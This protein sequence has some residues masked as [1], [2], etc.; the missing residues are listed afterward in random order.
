MGHSR[1]NLG[2]RLLVNDEMSGLRNRA[3]RRPLLP[4]RH[5]AQ[6]L[7]LLKVHAKFAVNQKA[8][9]GQFSLVGRSITAKHK[10][11]MRNTKRTSFIDQLVFLLVVLVTKSTT[12][13]TAGS[14]LT[15]V[16]FQGM[17]PS[18]TP[19]PI[20]CASKSPSSPISPDEVDLVNN[21][22]LSSAS[23]QQMTNKELFNVLNEIYT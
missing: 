5:T 15:R 13:H 22:L 14:C 1:Q 8:S 23:A 11:N 7:R 10:Q 3:Q 17:E 12:H 19:Q 2:Q 20:V 9:P 16:P 18:L 21:G 4:T 6:R